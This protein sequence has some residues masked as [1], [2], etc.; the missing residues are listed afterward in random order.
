MPEL[1]IKPVKGQ[2]LSLQ[3]P[4]EAQA[5]RLVRTPIWSERDG[6]W[7]WEPQEPEH[8]F[9]KVRRPMA[10][11]NSNGAWNRCYLKQNTGHRWSV[12]GGSG[13]TLR[14]KRH[15]GSSPIPGIWLACGHHRNGVLLAAI[16]AQMMASELEQNKQ[17]MR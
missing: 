10:R 16:T 3:G 13:P 9:R 8:P 2:M 1:A 17:Q 11:N 7:L 14:M 4:R 15:P 12:G 5:N 6:L